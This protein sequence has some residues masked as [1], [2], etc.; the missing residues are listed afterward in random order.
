MYGLTR[1]ITLAFLPLFL[2]GCGSGGE[3][4]DT[5]LQVDC[6]SPLFTHTEPLPPGTHPEGWITTGNSYWNCD[7]GREYYH[8]DGTFTGR[9]T[10]TDFRDYNEWLTIWRACGGTRPPEAAGDWVV[11][12]DALCVRFDFLPGIIG[13]VDIISEPDGLPVFYQA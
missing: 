7:G 12:D 3:D 1:I 11:A 2:A 4:P 5:R 6:S 9:L 8:A 13:C 10:D